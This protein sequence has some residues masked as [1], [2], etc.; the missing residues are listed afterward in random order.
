M[1][2]S[3]A[4]IYNAYGKLVTPADKLRMGITPPKKQAFGLAGNIYNF[5]NAGKYRARFYTISDS[6]QG[7]DTLSR[8][9][10]VRWSREMVWQLPPVRA[11]MRILADFSIGN[12]YD[13]IYSGVNKDWWNHAEKWLN[14]EWYPACNVRGSHFD[15]KTSLRTES[16]LIDMDG[17]YLIV[18][19]AENDAPKF[20]I[21]QNNRI[22]NQDMDNM[23]VESGPM[24]GAIISDGVFYSRQGKA[25]GYSVE[26]ANNLVN[27]MTTES[28]T[29]IFSA[30]DASL[31]LDPEF[32][33]KLR[34]VPA[35]GAAILQAL[36]VQELDQ[37]MMDKLKVES[38]VQLVEKTP[39]GQSPQELQNTLEELINIGQ[40]TGLQGG[41]ISP[42]LHAVQIVQG[43]EIKYVYADGGEVKSLAT[44]SPNR[45]AQEYMERLETQV[46]SMLSVPHQLVYS[47]D[48]TSGRITSSIAEIFRSGIAR[49]QGL[50]DKQARFRVCWA[51]CKAAKAGIIPENNEENLFEVISFSH[52]AE[53]SLDARYDFQIIQDSYTSGLSS[54]GDA[55]EKLYNRSAQQTLDVQEKEQTAFFEAVKRVAEKT[56]VDAATIIAN[57]KQ[58]VK[59]TR[60]PEAQDTDKESPD[61]PIT[62]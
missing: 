43:G 30:R 28:K 50:M 21:I 49:R 34:G 39:T 32:I 61:S 4:K 46:L 33:D 31:A 9:L 48:K 2:L 6:A 25:V 19:G 10:L 17:D 22:K 13:A 20:Q 14:L 58:G 57:W 62:A 44:N 7:M 18:Y 55:T 15:F 16:Q 41:G 59:L 5:Q 27:S 12:A 24:K 60:P 38:C 53:F 56:K 36:S 3:A 8:E 29:Q 26:N 45:E 23:I 40:Q 11:A 42:N 1:Q 37:Y 35:I 54:L 52:P 47:T 51:L